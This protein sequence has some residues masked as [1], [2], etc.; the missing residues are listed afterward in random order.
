MYIVGPYNIVSG[1]LEWQLIFVM[2]ANYPQME[3]LGGVNQFVLVADL[4]RQLLNLISGISGYNTVNQ[5]A[6]EVILRLN[7]VLKAVLQLPQIRVLQN[8]FFQV[9]AIIVN[10]LAGKKNQTF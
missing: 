10:Q 7:P 2:S 1:L 5:G 4:F 8:A 9:V 6:A 3:N